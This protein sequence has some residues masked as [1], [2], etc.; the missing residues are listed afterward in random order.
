MSA[1]YV[2]DFMPYDTG[3]LFLLL[4]GVHQP[5]VDEDVAGR[6]GKC[7]INIIVDDIKSVSEGLLRQGRQDP[8]ADIVNVIDDHRILNQIEMLVNSSHHLARQIFLLFDCDTQDHL[9]N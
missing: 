7:I 9:R 5:G 6:R 4:H 3:K 2:R 1:V 8:I